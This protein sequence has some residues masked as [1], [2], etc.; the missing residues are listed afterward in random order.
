[1]NELVLSAQGLT[2]RFHEGPLDVTVLRGV[3]QEQVA[4]AQETAYA[5]AATGAAW[6]RASTWRISSCFQ[7]SRCT[8][9]RH[10]TASSRAPSSLREA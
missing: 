4:L 3:A 1:M 9:P 8:C 7:A 10:I 6:M 5:G 2:K